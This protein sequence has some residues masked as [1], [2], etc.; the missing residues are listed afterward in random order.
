MKIILFQPEIP[1]NTGNI[2]R[3]CAVVGADLVLVRPLG[4]SI[5]EK[6]IRRAGL[7]YWNDVS[8][9]VI[10]DLFTYLEETERPFYFLSSKAQKL[11]TEVEYTNDCCLIF[12]SET[13]GLPQ[14]FREKWSEQFVRLPMREGQRCLNLASAACASIYEA[15]RQMGFANLHELI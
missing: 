15:W 13:S 6:R 11:Y 12:G 10:D 9:E 1:Q 3:T 7:D 14:E 5:T 4:F 2:V 8:I